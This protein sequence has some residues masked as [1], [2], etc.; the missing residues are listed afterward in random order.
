MSKPRKQSDLPLVVAEDLSLTDW[1][2][3]IAVPEH[4]RKFQ[5]ADYSF[6]TDAHRD[7]Y[8]ATV[9]SRS[10]NEV[11][12]ILRGFLITSGTLGS[13]SRTIRSLSALNTT[14]FNDLLE[15][16]EFV[17]R[18]FFTQRP[19]EGITW[20]LDL[21]PDNPRKALDA[22]DAYFVA[23]LAFMPEGRMH[24]LA[25][26]EAIIQQRYFHHANPRE[27]LL[28]LRPHEF[29]YLVALLFEKMGYRVSVTK[30]T[31]DGGI[32]V[33]ARN[34]EH[35]KTEFLLI[36]C[37]RYETN[38]PVSA[39]RELLGVVSKLQA[40]KGIVIST[41][42]FT[43][44]AKKEARET[45]RTELIGFAELNV[46]LNQH[47]GTRWPD[48]MSYCIRDIQHRLSAKGNSDDRENRGAS[49][50]AV[51]GALRDKAVQRP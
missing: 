41:S 2:E 16:T 47:M 23:N 26:A 12:Q 19:W 48:R 15:G 31:R 22:L 44:Q 37:K 27:A 20:V 24:G 42:S 51:Q 21:L 45:S 40:N 39:V 13:D 25:D 3:K 49:N 4:K 5:I 18:L 28:S 14:E 35:G 29:E 10:E 6:A 7:E 32:D 17:R 30:A 50:T 46:L 43:S 9:H 34:T 33:V 8:L 36:Q 38:V 1:L 11:K